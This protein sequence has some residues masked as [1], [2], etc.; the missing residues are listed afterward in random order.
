[1]VGVCA[2]LRAAETAR[3]LGTA[4]YDGCFS[5]REVAVLAAAV[6]QYRERV[7]LS[8]GRALLAEWA[9]GPRDTL[10][11]GW[12][13]A[14]LAPDDAYGAIGSNQGFVWVR[15]RPLHKGAPRY[16]RL[17]FLSDAPESEPE[18]E[19][20][21]GSRNGRGSSVGPSSGL[22]ADGEAFV[23]RDQDLR[24]GLA[25]WQ[26]REL[27]LELELQGTGAVPWEVEFVRT[28][29]A[30]F[31]WPLIAPCGASAQW[32]LTAEAW[33]PILDSRSVADDDRS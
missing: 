28:S 33:I 10:R 15:E 24:D 23:A 8:R 26:Q 25:A 30:P 27:E 31:E 13:R 7:Q 5:H 11:P 1:L 16:K 21:G 29:R 19:G 14:K 32:S 9:T 4:P 22:S 20:G 3:V 12:E 18:P 17:V 2:L 6:G